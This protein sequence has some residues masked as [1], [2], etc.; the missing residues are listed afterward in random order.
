MGIIKRPIIT[1]KTT[2]LGEKLSQYGFVV[3]ETANKI[4]IKK[5]VED[6]YGVTV[7]TVNTMRY[8]GKKKRN[9]KTHL[10]DGRTNSLKKAIV[11]VK[12]GDVIDFYSNI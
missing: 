10:F 11:S 3:E 6:M 12:E 1:E 5:A 4:E 7:E 8:A 9:K 2:S